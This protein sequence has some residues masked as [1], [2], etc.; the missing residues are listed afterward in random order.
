MICPFATP[1]LSE[2]ALMWSFLLL[3]VNHIGK[4]PTAALDDGLSYPSYPKTPRYYPSGNLRWLENLHSY[5]SWLGNLHFFQ[6]KGYI[7]RHPFSEK[8]HRLPEGIHPHPLRFHQGEWTRDS[9]PAATNQAQ[10]SPLRWWRWRPRWKLP[11][12]LSHRVAG[13]EWLTNLG[14]LYQFTRIRP[15]YFASSSKMNV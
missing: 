6:K 1:S 14:K 10:K 11:T 7:Y 3:G 12:Y 4:S 9:R 13:T 8:K 15:S 5:L 2:A